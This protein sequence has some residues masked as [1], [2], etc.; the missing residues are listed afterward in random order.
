MNSVLLNKMMYAIGLKDYSEYEMYNK[1]AKLESKKPNSIGVKEKLYAREDINEA[2]AYLK[3]L[4]YISDERYCESYIRY[5]MA[6]KWGLSKIKQKLTF[7]KKISKDIIEEKISIL[8]INEVDIIVKL[9]ETK[10]R[11]KDLKDMKIKS[12]AYRFLMSKGFNGG[13][14]G[15]A[16]KI[17]ENN[18][19]GDY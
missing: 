14:I 19:D 18:E 13:D 3:E 7:E 10:F 5:G 11:N 9:L 12:K 8:E 17:D 2:I 15:K 16:L 1:F 4:S 6:R